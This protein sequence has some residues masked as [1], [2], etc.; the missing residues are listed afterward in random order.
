MA[1]DLHGFGRELETLIRDR[2]P[3]TASGSGEEID[4]RARVV[5]GANQDLRQV[6]EPLFQNYA[7]MMESKGRSCE[8]KVIEGSADSF[9]PRRP[10]AEFYF[11]LLGV[12]GLSEC[13][14]RFEHEE[15]DWLVISRPALDG[16]GSRYD[17]GKRAL[18][19]GQRFARDAEAALQQFLRRAI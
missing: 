11:G 13:F 10:F 18:K 3:S 9:P 6:I 15:G 17:S 19:S 1:R 14:I 4:A 12:P 7:E 8:F 2:G 5:S 16:K